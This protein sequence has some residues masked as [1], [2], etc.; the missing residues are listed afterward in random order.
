MIRTI[1]LCCFSVALTL[2]SVVSG[3]SSGGD[4]VMEK[5]TIDNGVDT[6]TGGNF[7]LKGTV[8]QAD[9]G[10]LEGGR[11]VLEGGFWN[12]PTA[13]N[14]DILFKNSFE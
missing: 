3:Q 1:H 11:Y 6:S 5:S 10:S 4:Y 13:Q 12:A 8:G 7:T 9:A 14:V 2:T